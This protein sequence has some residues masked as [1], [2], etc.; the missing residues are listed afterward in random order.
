[1]GITASYIAMPVTVGSF[2]PFT[3]TLGGIDPPIGGG[4][5]IGA[6]KND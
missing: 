1:M 4:W 5:D 6:N 2:Q 3:N